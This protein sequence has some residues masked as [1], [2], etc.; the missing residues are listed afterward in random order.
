MDELKEVIEA[1]DGL[2]LPLK[3]RSMGPSWEAASAV[4]VVSCHWRRPTWGCVALVRRGERVYAHRILARLGDRYVTKGDDRIAWDRP[5]A[6]RPEILG[7]V[8]AL[9]P[10]EI[11]V[12]RDRAVAVR[13]TMRALLAWP[14]LP[15]IR[16][17]R[18]RAEQPLGSA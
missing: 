8:I 15:L 13:E 18:G 2:A 1:A 12:P 16:R 4:Q 10:G 5:L 3:G 17:L 9:L 14:L 7:V 6:R 11:P